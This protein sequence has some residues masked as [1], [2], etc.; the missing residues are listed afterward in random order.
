MRRKKRL[1]DLFL[2]GIP[3]G[4]DSGTG[5]RILICSYCEH[6]NAE[7]GHEKINAGTVAVNASMR[8]FSFAVNVGK[9]IG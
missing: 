4:D 5:K 9:K 3:N 7:C 1:T 6:E 2:C 8:A